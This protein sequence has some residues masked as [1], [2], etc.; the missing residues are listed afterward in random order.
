MEDK[1][2]YLKKTTI[3]TFPTEYTVFACMFIVIVVLSSVLTG[4]NTVKL[5]NKSMVSETSVELHGRVEAE[6]I[7]NFW[8][9][10]NYVN[11]N[12]AMGRFL[13]QHEINDVVKMTNGYLTGTTEPLSE[14]VVADYANKTGEFSKS[15]KDRG[16]DYLYVTLPHMCDKYDNK[17]PIGITD[18]TNIILDDLNAAMQKNRVQTIDLRDELHEADLTTYDIFFKTDH[19][20]TMQ[21][22]YFA[23]LELL[24]YISEKYDIDTSVKPSDIDNYI[25]TTHN[26]NFLGSNGRRTGVYYTGLDDFSLMEPKY[27]TKITNLDSDT[28]GTL[29]DMMFRK[30]RFT[31]G[32]YFSRYTYDTVLAPVSGNW[33]NSDAPIEK[34]IVIVGD[35][36]SK[37]VIPFLVLTFK[38]VLFVNNADSVS[39]IDD[40][41]LEKYSPDIIISLYALAPAMTENAYDWYLFTY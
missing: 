9:K 28:S 30:E 20:W 7:E 18:N 22:G 29:S 23:Y 32:D 14:D 24:R 21:G 36:M 15:L 17:M 4:I 3:Y 26:N 25:I 10:N 38:N 34:N 40:N 35:S 11:I 13:N 37:A 6:F 27:D 16:I 31:E 39:V 1:R 19:H 8:L 41:Y 2:L 12:G 33:K 5:H